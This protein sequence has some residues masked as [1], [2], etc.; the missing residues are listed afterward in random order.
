MA[1]YIYDC[2]IL[3]DQTNTYG[4]DLTAEAANKTDYENNYQSQ[5]V[6]VN[7]LIVS[8]TSFEID[9][10]WAQFKALI[11]GVNLTWADVKEGIVGKSYEL[12]LITNSLL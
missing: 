11:D 9:K 12:H 4:F 8:E 5:T 6:K 10:T 2:T 1:D 3:K 7:D